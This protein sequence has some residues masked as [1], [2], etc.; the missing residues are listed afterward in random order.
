[1]K[2]Y[3]FL[4]M[5]ITFNTYA[6]DGGNG[7]E[8]YVCYDKALYLESE[9][10]E[11]LN[12]DP[13]AKIIGTP[14]LRDYWEYGKIYSDK[15][16]L[17]LGEGSTIK[18][19]LLFVIDR[20]ATVE[21]LR[22]QRLRKRIEEL[23]SF[24]KSIP[25]VELILSNDANSI[26]QPK[27]KQGEFCY[28]RQVAFQVKD[29]RTNT[30]KVLINED[31]FKMMPLDHQTG[32]ILHELILEEEVK[33]QGEKDSDDTRYFNY[34]ISSNY[35]NQIK[36]KKNGYSKEFSALVKKEGF[37][38]L[39][40]TEYDKADYFNVEGPFY[41]KKKKGEQ[42]IYELVEDNAQGTK[43]L[44][45]YFYTKYDLEI[46]MD[47][48]FQL[49]KGS[50]FLD[51][52]S[53]GAINRE[54]K[55]LTSPFKN[56]KMN[57]IEG[58]VIANELKQFEK[59]YY[60]SHGI[61]KDEYE[62]SY[63]LSNF[64]SALLS[65]RG[66][67]FSFEAPIKV[68]KRVSYIK[69]GKNEGVEGRTLDL[70]S[71]LKQTLIPQETLPGIKSAQAKGKFTFNQ[72]K[73]GEQSENKKADSILMSIEEVSD[74]ELADSQANQ[75]LKEI[76]SELSI[77]S[78]RLA[79]VEEKVLL[80]RSRTQLADDF[81]QYGGCEISKPELLSFNVTNKSLQFSGSAMKVSCFNTEAVEA[82]TITFLMDGNYQM[83]NVRGRSFFEGLKVKRWDNHY[84]FSAEG[85]LL[86]VKSQ[87]IQLSDKVTALKKARCTWGHGSHNC[88]NSIY[89]NITEVN[90]VNGK[91]ES[92][93]Y[94]LTLGSQAFTQI[95]F[96]SIKGVP[97]QMRFNKKEKKV[98]QITLELNG[99]Y[100]V[101][102]VTTR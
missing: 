25:E 22:P 10:T 96:D 52:N 85:E 83:K 17:D 32:L 95:K 66:I 92:L 43:V 38:Y 40:D 3:L 14:L 99:D 12:I 39:Y 97:S 50:T 89:K 57:L 53:Y 77:D 30:P 65:W 20:L 90:F 9:N 7:G 35:I 11:S 4:L 33:F 71:S 16:Q 84:F 21:V 28:F 64:S 1:M 2:S 87:E 61:D 5:V 98:R 93:T 78:F 49:K 23:E 86:T 94:N 76:R 68:G 41:I 24:Y 63:H 80:E 34:T 82:E 27:S 73:R 72:Y 69:Y 102:K 6:K 56:F 8:A 15:Y 58:Q 31:I 88:T 18:E 62:N 36:D 37:F 55:L 48:D 19:K 26:I 46:E 79:L 70:S 101:T 59:K 13:S 67:D 60:K 75:F 45:H 81:Y 42:N 29:P 44:S 100:K 51:G 47:T 54:V 91:I 74:V